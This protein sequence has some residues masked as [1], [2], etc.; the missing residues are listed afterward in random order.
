MA[1]RTTAA[2]NAAIPTSVSS[3]GRVYATPSRP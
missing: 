3:T 2:P 1:G